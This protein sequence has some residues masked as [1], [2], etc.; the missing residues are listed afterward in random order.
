MRVQ[1]AL[2]ASPSE[3]VMELLRAAVSGGDTA[4]VDALSNS[5]WWEVVPLSG[6]FCVCRT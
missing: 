3:R 6:F 1:Y 2:S 5:A 4:I